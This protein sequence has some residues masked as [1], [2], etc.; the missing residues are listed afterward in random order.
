MPEAQYYECYRACGGRLAVHP[1]WVVI[2]GAVIDPTAETAVRVLEELG[3]AADDPAED[4]YIG[5][6][7]PT[8]FLRRRLLQTGAWLPVGADFLGVRQPMGNTL[9]A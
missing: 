4:A 6:P 5:I 3:V 8:D 1:A 7:I 9:I 2:H